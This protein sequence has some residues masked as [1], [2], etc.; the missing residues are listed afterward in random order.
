MDIYNNKVRSLNCIKIGGI[1]RDNIFWVPKCFL[2][3]YLI[4]F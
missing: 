2:Q 1:V 3:K 4:R